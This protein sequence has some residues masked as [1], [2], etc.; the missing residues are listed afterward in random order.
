MRTKMNAHFFLLW[1]CLWLPI[2]FFAG[3]LTNPGSPGFV[4]AFWNPRAWAVTF[5]L[6]GVA[7]GLLYRFRIPAKAVWDDPMTNRIFATFFY[8]WVGWKGWEVATR[9]ENTVMKMVAVVV[10][11]FALGVAINTI[12]AVVQ[13][14]R[15]PRP[16]VP[17]SPGE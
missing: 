5:P 11:L 13:R 2:A 8:N 14:S 6:C 16:S 10:I 17:Q 15:K 7:A 1:L 9:R 12:I 4:T 3:L